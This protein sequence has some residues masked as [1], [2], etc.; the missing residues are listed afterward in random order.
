MFDL[1]T[2]EGEEEIDNSPWDLKR[3]LNSESTELH[4]SVVVK[5]LPKGVGD[6][7]LIVYMDAISP[8]RCA[9]VKIAGTLAVVDFQDYV[10]TWSRFSML[11]FPYRSIPTCN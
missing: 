1:A 10:G 7:V 6:H 11:L 2:V 4:K 5:G 8:V 3:K 9:S